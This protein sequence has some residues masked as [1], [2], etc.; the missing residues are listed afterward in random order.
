[1]S[2]SL[3]R[4]VYGDLS[5]F[6]RVTS[7]V[8]Y[9]VGVVVAVC[10]II[11]GLYLLITGGGGDEVEED[12]KKI[13]NNKGSVRLMGVGVLIFALVIIGFSYANNYAASHSKLYVAD[14]GATTI[15]DTLFGGR[16]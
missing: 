12:G 14:V 5:S 16:R 6:G 3:G 1:M 10:L 13:T 8:G 11:L 15:F 2:E 9:V 4:E 7:K